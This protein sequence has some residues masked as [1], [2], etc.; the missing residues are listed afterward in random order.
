MAEGIDAGT[1]YA[2][3]VPDL[4]R[5]GERARR[6]INTPAARLGKDIAER[7]AKPLT[8]GITRAV[9]DGLNQAGERAVAA[10]TR[11]ARA[12]MRAFRE[13]VAKSRPVRIPV[14]IDQRAIARILAGLR[15]Q[16]RE[17]GKSSGEEFGDGFD[18]KTREKTSKTPVGPA[19]QRSRKS[20]EES[21]GGFADGFRKRVDAALK[22]LP[23]VR[24]GVARNEAEQQIKDL[25]A[26][27]AALSGK[28][29]GVD[30]D[31]RQ[32]VREV[33]RI[34]AALAELSRTSPDIQVQADTA[35]AA[36]QLARVTAQ[37]KALDG[38]R[39][40]VEVDVDTDRVGRGL[41]RLSGIFAQVFGGISSSAQ[42][43][44]QTISE[45][46]VKAGGQI[47]VSLIGSAAAAAGMTADTGGL[48]I[49]LGVLATTALVA[50]AAVA[51]LTVGLVF[52]APL[53][54]SLGG[55]LGAAVTG[56]FGVA[57]GAAVVGFGIS[58]IADAFTAMGEAEKSAGKDAAQA[59]ARQASLAS[60]LDGVRNAQRS[61]GNT[62][63]QVAEGAR[64]AAQR[65]E[66]SERDLVAAQRDALA[67]QQD[68]TR[69]RQEAREALEDLDGQVRSNAL[70]QRQ[71]NLDVAEARREL[72]AVLANPR[73]TKDQ[74]E[75]AR[76][77]Y[78]SEVLQQEDLRRR[79]QRLQAEQKAAVKAGVEGSEQVRAVR[80]RQAA[81][82][83]RVAAATRA[84]ADSQRAQQEQAR[85]GAFQLAQ[86]QQALAAAQRAARQATVSAGTAGSAA[87]DKLNEAMAKLSPNARAFVREL[88][89]LRGPFGLLRRFVQDRLLDG[90]AG[91]VRDLSEKWL[92]ALYPLLG[93]L[94]DRF[95]RTF[96]GIFA[97][98]GDTT[99][100][101]NV[102]EAVEGFGRMFT[103]IGQS[104]PEFIDAL[105]RVGA[106]SVPVLEEIGD[107]IGR[108]FDKF[109]AWIK[110]A[111]E[112][113]ALDTFMADAAQ[114]LEDIFNITGEVIG[115]IG[116]L[117]EIFF[118]QSKEVSKSF[119]GRV[120]ETLQKIRAWLKDPENQEK[121]RDWVQKVIEFTGKIDDFIRKVRDEW[122]PKI[123]EW[124]DRI[125]RWVT[126]AETWIN[127]IK[128][129]ASLIA[130]P[131]IAAKNAAVTALGLLTAAQNTARDRITAAWAWVRDRIGAAWTWIRDN[132]FTPMR[133]A[134]TQGVPAAFRAG[135]EAIGRWWDGLRAKARTP[136]LFVVNSVINPLIAGYNKLAKVFGVPEAPP[137][138]FGTGTI[139]QAATG[140]ILPGYTP[141]RDVHTFVSPSGGVLHLSGGEPV[142][143]PEVGRVL[144]AGWVHGVNRAA[145]T[146][147]VGGVR[148]FLGGGAGDGLGDLYRLARE[149]ASDVVR[150]SRRVLADPSGS[151]SSLGNRL[152]GLIPQQGLG[153]GRLLAGMS[154]RVLGA[155]A[156]NLTSLVSDF[157]AGPGSGQ[158]PF[159]G[160]AG[161]MRALRA[162]FPGLTLISGFRPGARTLSGSRSYHAADRAVDLPPSRDVAAYIHRHF[163]SITRELITPFQEFNLLNGRPHTYTGAVWHQHNFAGGNAHDH[164]AAR[165]GGIVPALYD[166]GGYLPPGISTVYNGTGRPEPVLTD[167]QWRTMI[168]ATRGGDTREVHHYHGVSERITPEW[169]QRMQDRR[170]A[171]ARAGRPNR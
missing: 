114:A 62:R 137:I 23:P 58:G 162:Q 98:L 115:L 33:E 96:D 125:D 128:L 149:K 161:M 157:Q 99:F 87:M 146:G 130:A 27:L 145:R 15:R 19:R 48:N 53:M 117:I 154:R 129:M 135:V 171:L 113:G 110:S 132:V 97:A 144:G 100:I 170:D 61:L 2:E 165:L 124:M 94:A 30:I 106:A 148:Q 76:I 158:S 32:A 167:G 136:V 24:I 42:A 34:E 41:G 83:E 14:D 118:P 109:S 169:V 25:T 18:R 140:G 9:R 78:E 7:M 95:N 105:G 31:S 102:T 89:R 3:V 123:Q 153:F 71:A 28:R 103:R 80:E 21:G 66:D 126:G 10:A 64:R 43:F 47:G 44:F 35:A 72:D 134:I 160:S 168:A 150:G 139:T 49:V 37:A 36:A 29:I 112:T 127:R 59:A 20:G 163:R 84:L 75:Q 143:R 81:A 11:H 46:A 152:I 57:A 108:I 69:A 63:A 90:V 88:D 56:L 73:A 122:I 111:D 107:L 12:Y 13:T 39:V 8:G 68:L 52:L 93:G 70:A 166:Q 120:E 4:S 155:L 119:L 79:G 104:I 22:A 92:P 77:R 17:S 147:G 138:K 133:T 40:E 164:W 141:G 26:D 65:V 67:I 60:A 16:A 38:T 51:T 121:I 159:G 6:Q 142:L 50:A 54:L 55:L 82:D 5:F 1:M 131:F 74:I 91:Q 156:R 101:D 85:Q 86:A 116:D 151:L 45:G